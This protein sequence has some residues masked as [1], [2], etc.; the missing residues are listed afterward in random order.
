[1]DSSSTFWLPTKA[2]TFTGH[3][4]TF[5]YV[6]MWLSLFFFLAIVIAMGVFVYKYWRKRPDQLA[7]AQITHN[8]H[9]EFWWTFIPLIMVIVF[10]FYGFK[11]FLDMNIAPANAMQ[12][13]VRA[14]KW[15]WAFEYPEGASSD[16]LVV[17]VNHPVELVMFSRDVLHSF[18]VP[19][20]RVKN[21]V[22]PNRY[23]RVWFHA[24]T[25]GTFPVWCA[26]FCGTNH[27]NMLTAVRVLE[28]GDYENWLKGA[29]DPG[30]GLAP[31]EF[32]KLLYTKRGCSS[33]HT[34][35][36]SKLVGP[37]W[38]GMWGTSRKLTS[39]LSVTA[40][41]NY[42]RNSMMN[43]Q[44]EVVEGFPPVMPP[45]KGI[46]SDKEV[47]ALIAFIQSLK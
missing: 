38:K 39:G 19:A 20:F 34:L 8:A 11:G 16:T 33:C 42:V 31:V 23:T 44:G 27:S 17:P 13:K 6:L 26:E 22:I 18:F 36:G 9:L 30:K 5:F 35:D 28:F 14:Q 21:D 4:D 46:L 29:S 32:G 40:D 45:F 37:S 25:T 24:T 10:F 2:S 41:E 15:S 3:I 47:D 1:M 7:Q 12:I 43:P